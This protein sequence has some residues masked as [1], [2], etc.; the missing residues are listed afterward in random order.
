MSKQFFGNTDFCSVCRFLFFVFCIKATV[1]LKRISLLN[2][3]SSC[4]NF[5]NPLST[6]DW[7]CEMVRKS[8]KTCHKAE[9]LF[10]LSYLG[11]C[12]LPLHS[13][14]YWLYS[15]PVSR[16]KTA[17]VYHQQWCLFSILL[18]LSFSAL[19]QMPLCIHQDQKPFH[20]DYHYTR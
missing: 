4:I 19:L 15:L 14:N 7:P 8:F 6:E 11:K 17:Q 5:L 2:L 12:I 20:E 10:P 18:Q 16:K 1:R 9:T 13:S 3:A